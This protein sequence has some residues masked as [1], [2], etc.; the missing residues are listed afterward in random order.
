MACNALFTYHALGF[1]FVA[2]LCY[3]GCGNA[4][5][6]WMGL[7]AWFDSNAINIIL[8]YTCYQIKIDVVSFR[9]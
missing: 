5:A 3:R 4:S 1:G 8:T 7:A 2:N 6:K 9:I